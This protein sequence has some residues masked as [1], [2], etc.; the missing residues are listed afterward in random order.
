MPV[1][2]TLHWI[3]E[4]SI[5]LRACVKR[6]AQHHAGIVVFADEQGRFVGLLT[7][8]DIFRLQAHG[9]SLEEPVSPHINT[10]P[11]TVTPDA[12]SAEILKVMTDRGITVVPMVRADGSV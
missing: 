4:P 5:T 7:A 6:F 11:I 8:G 12:T 9:A 3:A 2:E 1:E 10:R